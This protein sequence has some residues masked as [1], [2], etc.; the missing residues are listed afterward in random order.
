M[1]TLAAVDR[2]VHHSIILEFNIPSLLKWL[3]SARGALSL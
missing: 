3:H 2:L 1:T